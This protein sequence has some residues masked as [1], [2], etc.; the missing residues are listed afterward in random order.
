MAE[1]EPIN[2]KGVQRNATGQFVAGNTM[3]S[4]RKNARNGSALIRALNEEAVRP[5]QIENA[6]GVVVETIDRQTLL[7]RRVW[8]AALEVADSEKLTLQARQLIFDRLAPPPRGDGEEDGIVP[9]HQQIYNTVAITF[10]T[11]LD[12]ETGGHPT[13][14]QLLTKL[15]SVSTEEMLGNGDQ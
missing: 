3:V 9:A 5:E 11:E 12:A 15:K 10:L 4:L 1:I 7:A 2:G 14:D 13:I 6:E 8:E